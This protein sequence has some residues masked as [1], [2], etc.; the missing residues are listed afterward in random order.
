MANDPT[1]MESGSNGDLALKII[2]V[3]SFSMQPSCGSGIRKGTRFGAV[4]LDRFGG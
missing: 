2:M 1:C 3:P 4:Y